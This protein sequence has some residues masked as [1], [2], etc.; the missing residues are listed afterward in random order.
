MQKKTRKKK[1]LGT[2]ARK[3]IER[4]FLANI[5]VKYSTAFFV[6]KVYSKSLYFSMKQFYF[7]FLIKGGR[8]ENEQKTEADVLIGCFF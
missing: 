3:D 7:V 2:M 1:R 4:C 6:S 5:A 8:P